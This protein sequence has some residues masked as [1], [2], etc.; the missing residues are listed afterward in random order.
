MLTK[1]AYL[2]SGRFSGE[3]GAGDGDVVFGDTRSTGRVPGTEQGI[4]CLYPAHSFCLIGIGILV[5]LPRTPIL[6][7]FSCEDM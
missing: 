3:E 2:A 7:S 1:T 6:L 4:P 5:I